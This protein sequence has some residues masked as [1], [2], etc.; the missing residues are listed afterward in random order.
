MHY[1]FNILAALF[2]ALFTFPSVAG[3]SAAL[4]DADAEI[5]I[6]RYD[7]LA[8]SIKS[9]VHK[10]Q[11][12]LSL[13]KHALVAVHNETPW[14]SYLADSL[15]FGTAYCAYLFGANYT[16]NYLEARQI[17]PSGDTW[18]NC[19]T[20]SN[21]CVAFSAVA[22]KKYFQKA[23]G[24]RAVEAQRRVTA[25]NRQMLTAMINEMKDRLDAAYQARFT[26]HDEIVKFLADRNEALP[27]LEPE[28][29][30]ELFTLASVTSN[31]PLMVMVL[32]TDHSEEKT[33]HDFLSG[34]M[35][36][37]RCALCMTEWEDATEFGRRGALIMHTCKN[38]F[39]EMCIIVCIKSACPMCN[40][41][42]E[43]KP[44]HALWDED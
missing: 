9:M 26:E 17:C 16:L 4:S 1:C 43:W 25:R 36:D 11:Q 29:R 32:N 42:G 24:R 2:F 35:S 5:I 44:L 27:L 3:K 41:E 37:D 39:H 7:D 6:V 38:I 33:I 34:K 22:L 21:V 28:L 14:C 10:H 12:L 30:R 8:H 13:E 18:Q 19:R 40:T 23:Q 15:A 31:F 20:I